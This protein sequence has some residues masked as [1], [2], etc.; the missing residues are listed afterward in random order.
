M[1]LSTSPQVDVIINSSDAV[2]LN[3]S[4]QG[5]PLSVLRW[6]KDGAPLDPDSSHISITTFRRQ[7]PTDTYPYSSTVDS[8]F[9]PTPQEGL[10]Y[11]EAV[12]E[13]TLLPPI[14]R[15]DIADYT[16]EVE[17]HFVLNYTETSDNIPVNVF[18]ECSFSYVYVNKMCTLLIHYS[19]LH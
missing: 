3:C 2:I 12:S 5:Y 10:E 14:V 7:D 9:E 8:N 18:G 6:R 13:L 16:C 11:F 1:F 19:P 17:A 15:T 4:L